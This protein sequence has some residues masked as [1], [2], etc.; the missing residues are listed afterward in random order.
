MRIMCPVGKGISYKAETV[1][2]LRDPSDINPAKS[3]TTE[4]PEI[5]S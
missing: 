3:E 1:L 5:T 4:F 2:G